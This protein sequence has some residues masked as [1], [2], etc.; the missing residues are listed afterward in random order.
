[1]RGLAGH[2]R[3]V[4]RLV[5]PVGAAAA[6]LCGVGGQPRILVGMH[7]FTLHLGSVEIDLRVPLGCQPMQPAAPDLLETVTLKP[8]PAR[9]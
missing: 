2:A 9:E 4:T 6:T 7:W 8:C 5:P 3:P 1:M